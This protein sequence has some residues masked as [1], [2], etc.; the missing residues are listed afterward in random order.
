MLI[1]NGQIRKI[2]LCQRSALFGQFVRIYGC[3]ATGASQQQISA[4]Q[5]TR[6]MGVEMIF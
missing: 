1:A 2:H 4:G 5:F 6:G 3:I